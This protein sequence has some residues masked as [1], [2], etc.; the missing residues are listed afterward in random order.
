MFV[1]Q[2]I[3]GGLRSGVVEAVETSPGAGDLVVKVENL[4][5]PEEPEMVFSDE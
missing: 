1:T 4:L 2:D 3:G 5:R